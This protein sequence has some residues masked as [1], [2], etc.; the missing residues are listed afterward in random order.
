MEEEL[1]E[2]IKFIWFVFLL[3]FRIFFVECNFKVGR[4]LRLFYF[5]L[6]FLVILGN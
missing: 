6:L 2:I 1:E 3:N 4:V 5:Y